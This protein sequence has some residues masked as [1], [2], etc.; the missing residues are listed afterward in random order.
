MPEIAASELRSQN[1]GVCNL[2]TPSCAVLV[3][4][5]DRYRDLWTPFF[6]LFWRYWPDCPFPVYLGSN[7]ATH[8]DKR[9]KSLSA[10]EDQSWSK[11]LRFFLENI[12]AQYVL[13]LLEDFFLNRQPPT[14]SLLENLAALHKLNGTVLRLYPHPKPNKRLKGYP[15]I[16][17]LHPSAPYR[18]ST[19]PAIWNRTGLL[20]LLQEDESPWQF[21]Q[22]GTIRSQRKLDGFYSTYAPI[23]S[24]HHV[25][26]RGEWFRS[27]VKRYKNQALGCD[28]TSRPVMGQFTAA[29]KRLN[30]G[31]RWMLDRIRDFRLSLRKSP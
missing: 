10:G 17:S 31:R 26:E 20:A 24:Y 30:D 14:S 23:V 5:C 25:V 12:D 13:L 16:G 27:A 7:F 28:F 9:V 11:N 6:A 4:S 1:A 8:A 3:V 19:Q 15:A 21:E 2:E 18:V 29:K 22:Q